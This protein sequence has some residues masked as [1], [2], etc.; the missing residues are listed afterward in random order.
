MTSISR[1]HKLAQTPQL[2]VVSNDAQLQAIG[3]KYSELVDDSVYTSG[4]LSGNGSDMGAFGFLA[5]DENNNV[6]VVE[7]Y[8]FYKVSQTTGSQLADN[9]TCVVV[10]PLDASGAGNPI[11]IDK[12]DDTARNVKASTV[13][14]DMFS[15]ENGNFLYVLPDRTYNDA[16]N[17][18]QMINADKSQQA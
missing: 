8:D 15:M 5:G 18:L 7:Y 1:L 2:D 13:N 4:R 6:F 14:N 3:E 11:E 10:R 9:V 17:T 12:F 16:L